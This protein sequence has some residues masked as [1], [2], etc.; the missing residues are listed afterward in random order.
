MSS[1]ETTPLPIGTKY[2]TPGYFAEVDV[3][4][5]RD[6]IVDHNRLKNNWVYLTKEGAKEARDRLDIPPKKRVAF[7]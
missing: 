1:P 2:Y 3:I 7:I 6:D 5:W 4:T